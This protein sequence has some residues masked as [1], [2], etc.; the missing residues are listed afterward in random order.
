MCLIAAK[1]GQL[2]TRLA[3]F[4]FVQVVLRERFGCWARGHVDNPFGLSEVDPENRTV[5]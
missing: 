5:R 4:Y 3:G 1:F 2:V